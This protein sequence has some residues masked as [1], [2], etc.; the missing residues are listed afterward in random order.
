MEAKAF[1]SDI[2]GNWEAL[3]KTLEELDTLGIKEI[4]CLGDIVGYGPDPDLC[5]E[6]VRKRCT[7]VIAGNHDWAVVEKT[8]T[9]DFNAIARAAVYWTRRKLNDH[10]KEYLASLPL[11]LRTEKETLLVHAS[12]LRPHEWPY[13]MDEYSALIALEGCPDWVV[14]VGHSHVPEAYR[15]KDGR[16]ERFPF[17]F[18]LEKKARYLVN[19]GSVGQP[20]DGDPR[21]CCVIVEE[22]RMRLERI[23]YPVE[24]T[25]RKIRKKGL[26]L[27]LAHRIKE[28]W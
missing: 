2:H 6:A 13:I 8:P 11:T 7:G 16:I 27:F 5:L 1:I 18:T 17:P 23:T 9:E 20:R 21:A 14:M 10:Q 12:P 19:V 25:S 3:E 15:L 28:G 4:Y 22:N 24:I 26:P